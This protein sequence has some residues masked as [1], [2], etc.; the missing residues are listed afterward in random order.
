M[1]PWICEDNAGEF[2]EKLELTKLVK[3]KGCMGHWN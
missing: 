1:V 2:I 3:S